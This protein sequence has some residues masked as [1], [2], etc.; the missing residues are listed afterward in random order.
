MTWPV[1][2]LEGPNL[3]QTLSTIKFDKHGDRTNQLIYIC[4]S[5]TEGLDWAKQHNF[6][7]ALFVKSGTMFK[8]WDNWKK[9]IA[10]YP[11][12][13]LIAHLIKYPD[14]LL[15]LDD[16][17]WFMDLDIF[18]ISDF[19][20][21]NVTHPTPILSDKNLHDNYT[22]LWAKS[23]RDLISYR[24]NKF[25]QGLIARQLQANQ[26]IV[27]WNNVARD[28]KFFMYTDRVNL[29]YFDEYKNIAE[30]QFWIFNNEPIK[31][32][33]KQKLI[34]P[35]SGL[36]WMFNIIN[37]LTTNVQIIDISHVQIKFCEEL[38]TN[39]DGTDYGNIAW[40]FITQNNLTHFELDNPNLTKLER[41][42]LKSKSKFIKYVDDKF[43]E[44]LNQHNIT[45]F[46]KLWADAKATKNVKFCADNLIQWVINNDITEYNYIWC[47]N[48]LDYKWTLL[49]TTV[50][51]YQQFQLKVQ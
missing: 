31:I 27:N 22:P 37:P 48:I 19:T 6:T 20:I 17:C 47:S 24:T 3:N 35:G 16:Q 30:N 7:Q 8:D 23:G 29:E 13:G 25:G 32:V 46:A 36:S 9:L 41:L 42:M 15:Y 34:T 11:H 4:K 38:W 5:W 12:K 45:N 49:H 14:Q 43:L 2:L 10:E 39:W 44:S 1:V 50:K 21:E 26:I 28:L 18:R 40:E 51:E 33:N